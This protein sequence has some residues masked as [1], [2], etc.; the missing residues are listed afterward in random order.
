MNPTNENEFDQLLESLAHEKDIAAGLAFRW[1]KLPAHKREKLKN[2]CVELL[3][4]AYE[5][6][7]HFWRLRDA[8]ALG[9]EFC[10]RS[11]RLGSVMHLVGGVYLDMKKGQTA[12]GILQQA[13]QLAN[14]NAHVFETLVR[15][16]LFVGDSE[17]AANLVN[18]VS[19]S[20]IASEQHSTAR[21][22][23]EAAMKDYEFTSRIIPEKLKVCLELIAKFSRPKLNSDNVIDCDDGKGDITDVGPDKTKAKP[24]N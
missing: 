15:A 13:F 5:L 18:S 21:K 20:L 9:E 6:R 24:N 17:E 1:S 19:C 14:T 4:K 10:T 7:N 3:A 2:I 16:L 11:E 8:G 23:I 22:I 12:C